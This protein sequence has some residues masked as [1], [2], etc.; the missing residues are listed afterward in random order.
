MGI[1]GVFYR[2]LISLRTTS[3]V[4]D[5]R[6][7]EDN[8]AHPN[9]YKS[10]EANNFE[11]IKRHSSAIMWRTP[12][13][14]WH[15][16]PASLHYGP[17]MVSDL[18]GH[19]TRRIGN[20]VHLDV[21]SSATLAASRTVKHGCHEWLRGASRF[22]NGII[23]RDVPMEV[24]RKGVA[25][26]QFPYSPRS[27]RK[28]AS[29]LET[30][31][32]GKAAECTRLISLRCHRMGIEANTIDSV[33]VIAL[34]WY[35]GRRNHSGMVFPLL[36]NCEPTMVGV[37]Q[38]AMMF[39]TMFSADGNVRRRISLN[40][41][42]NRCAPLEAADSEDGSIVT[43][44]ATLHWYNIPPAFCGFCT[45]WDQ[46]FHLTATSRR[47]IDESGPKQYDRGSP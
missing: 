29:N 30:C 35:G 4:L 28:Y 15:G 18:S 46:C 38:A 37:F 3:C 27:D 7:A 33:N 32:S 20:M 2:R 25:E 22:S 6:S 45:H 9:G 14:Q 19:G 36:H 39:V 1:V 42:Q 5:T 31:I 24:L 41:N 34:R 21:G 47:H 8:A 16:F 17:V 26:T 43:L 12:Q 23:C 11:S 44:D 40:F 10:Q 13:P